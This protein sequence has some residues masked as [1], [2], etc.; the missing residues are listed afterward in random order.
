MAAAAAPELVKV[1]DTVERPGGGSALGYSLQ[2][3][4]GAQPTA[5]L[6]PHVRGY[7]CDVAGGHISVSLTRLSGQL[8]ADYQVRHNASLS[9]GL[10]SRQELDKSTTLAVMKPQGALQFVDVF[11]RLS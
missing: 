8:D 11:K 4:K 10:E 1:S 3:P 7:G 2:L 5:K 9:G 6:M